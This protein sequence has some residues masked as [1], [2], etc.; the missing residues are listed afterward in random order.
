MEFGSSCYYADSFSCSNK[1]AALRL[2]QQHQHL[3]RQGFIYILWQDRGII[4]FFR[5]IL[6]IRQVVEQSWEA[7]PKPEGLRK[8]NV[9]IT[10]AKEMGEVLALEFGRP[11][12]GQ[13]TT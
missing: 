12:V 6:L 2:N 4:L 10:V 5:F 7:H 11:A 8:G 9:A 3:L 13:E 1:F